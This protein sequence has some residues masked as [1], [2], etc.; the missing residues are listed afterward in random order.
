MT[1]AVALSEVPTLFTFP[2]IVETIDCWN[3]P[4]HLWHALVWIEDQRGK[5]NYT[6]EKIDETIAK[7]EQGLGGIGGEFTRQFHDKDRSS[8]TDFHA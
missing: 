8:D 2:K 6:E 1:R 3:R 4:K 7:L 5:G